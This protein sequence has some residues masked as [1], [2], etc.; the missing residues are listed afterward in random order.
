MIFFVRLWKERV[1]PHISL[2]LP[3]REYSGLQMKDFNVKIRWVKPCG[4]S[5]SG[6]EERRENGHVCERKPFRSRP[7]KRRVWTEVR[8]QQKKFH[9][10][11]P[12]LAALKCPTASIYFVVIKYSKEMKFTIRKLREIRKQN[13]TTGSLMKVHVWRGTSIGGSYGRPIARFRPTF[14]V[15]A[16]GLDPNQ[17]LK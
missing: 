13:S 12:H 4:Q 15:S 3:L 7:R 9:R 17:S 8:H 5:L 6:Q 16:F 2:F 11:L 1:N 10:Q 14:H